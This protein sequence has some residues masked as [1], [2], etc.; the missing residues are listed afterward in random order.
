MRPMSHQLEAWQVQLEQ[1]IRNLHHMVGESPVPYGT[2]PHRILIVD[3]LVFAS[4]E[5]Q[6]E[7]HHGPVLD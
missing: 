4:N 5:V 1:Q 6:V 2:E 3:H 7:R